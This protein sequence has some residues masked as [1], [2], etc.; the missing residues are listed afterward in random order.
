MSKDYGHPSN[1]NYAA[2]GSANAICMRCGRKVKRFDIKVEW[3]GIRVCN[4]CWDPRHPVT[5][6]IPVPMD[7]LPL[8]FA[9]PRPQAQYIQG[10]Q[11]GLSIWGKQYELNG[12]LVPNILWNNWAYP[13]GGYDTVPFNFLYFPQG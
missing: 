5:M 12:T 11:D 7:S 10:I 6:P 2:V 8:P 3:T 13:W 9:L 1:A 4:R